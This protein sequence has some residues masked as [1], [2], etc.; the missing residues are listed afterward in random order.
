MIAPKLVKRV[1]YQRLV[2]RSVV[3]DFMGEMLG[4]FG[5]RRTAITVLPNH[6]RRSIQAVRLMPLLVIDQQFICELTH[7]QLFFAC[8]G[9]TLHLLTPFKFRSL[10]D[11]IVLTSATAFTR[12]YAMPP[13]SPVTGPPRGLPPVGLLDSEQF[14]NGRTQRCC[15]LPLS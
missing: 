4:Y 7:D 8:F 13:V 15:A 11:A 6:C 5:N 1:P 9:K 10:P 14:S 12:C 3:A 2:N